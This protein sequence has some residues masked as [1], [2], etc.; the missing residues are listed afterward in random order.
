MKYTVIALLALAVLDGSVTAGSENTARR[1]TETT[2]P[3]DYIYR[4]RAYFEGFE[5]TVPPAGWTLV[6][7][8]IHQ[9]WIVG[10]SNPF[11]G[12]QRATVY[13]DFFL[14]GPQDEWLKFEYQ[15]QPGDDILGFAAFASTYWAI[16][17]YQNYNLIVTIDGVTVWDYYNDN[18]GAVS[19]EWSEYTVDL[20]SYAVG[21]LVTIGFGYV[22]F[23][24]AEGT[25]DAVYIGE[26]L[27]PVEDTSWGSVKALYR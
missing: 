19:F 25:F 5:D 4:D 21:Q 17:P 15:I 23:D 14:S 12:L 22:G 27:T 3:A 6:Q 13:W 20:S 1:A 8:N 26:E 18:N 24:G 10:L 2:D 16:D 9:T 7:T 11:E